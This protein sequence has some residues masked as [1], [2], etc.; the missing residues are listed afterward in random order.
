MA[1]RLLLRNPRIKP[2]LGWRFVDPHEGKPFTANSLSLLKN[3]VARY[4]QSNGLPIG[5]DFDAEIQDWI[6]RQL[7]DQS[8]HC[9][10]RGKPSLP[11]IDQGAITGTG[12]QG[13]KKW[14]ELHVW[15]L[16]SL[17]PEHEKAAWLANFTASLPCGECRTGWRR[18]MKQYP[19]PLNGTRDEMFNWTVSM[20]SRISAKLGK[21]TME[22]EDARKLYV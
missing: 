2:P 22:P 20:H 17:E 21:K 11:S 18:L 7:N 1:D 6:C 19:P 13:Q 14:R 12:Y 15:A 10:E 9:R 16:T 8:F 3:D 4:R 5:T